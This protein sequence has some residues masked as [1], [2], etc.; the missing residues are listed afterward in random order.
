VQESPQAIGARSCLPLRRACPSPRSNAARGNSSVRPVVR[1]PSR[2]DAAWARSHWRLVRPQCERLARH[3]G[4]WHCAV[5]RSLSALFRSPCLTDCPMVA[6][7]LRLDPWRFSDQGGQGTGPIPS[8]WPPPF[9][10]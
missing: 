10:A 9:C 2:C 6:S 4:G 3:C 7:Q 8:R 1:T 5:A